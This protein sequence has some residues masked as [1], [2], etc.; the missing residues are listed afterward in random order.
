V[1]RA[2]FYPQEGPTRRQVTVVLQPSD[3]P[4]LRYRNIDCF[5]V[6]PTRCDACYLPCSTHES[7]PGFAFSLLLS[8]PHTSDLADADI[9]VHNKALETLL[10]DRGLPCLGNVFV[11]KH[12]FRPGLETCNLD[13]PILDIDPPEFQ[14]VDEILM[15]CGT[16]S[17]DFLTLLTNRQMAG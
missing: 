9:L 11:V 12:H 13:L 5:D 7:L 10:G 3:P 2:L 14:I 15:Q 8:C 6:S 17:P 16:R 4:T 1:R